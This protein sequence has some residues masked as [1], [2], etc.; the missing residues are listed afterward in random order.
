MSAQKLRLHYGITSFYWP[1]DTVCR[2]VLYG[3]YIQLSSCIHQTVAHLKCAL[4]G[5]TMRLPDM[6]RRPSRESNFGDYSFI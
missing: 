3:G 4:E 5:E 6:L 1:E 2:V